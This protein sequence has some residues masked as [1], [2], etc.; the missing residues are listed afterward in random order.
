[1]EKHNKLYDLI[2]E[3]L[4]EN[5]DEHKEFYPCMNGEYFEAKSRDGAYALADLLEDCGFDVVHASYNEDT[6]MWEVYPD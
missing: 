3:C 5:D 4:H 1:M 2:L 6:M